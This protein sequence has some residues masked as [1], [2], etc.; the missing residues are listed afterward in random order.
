VAWYLRPSL[1][2]LDSLIAVVVSEFVAY[3]GAFV[4]GIPIYRFLYVRK[5]TAFWIAPTVGFL[6]GTIVMSVV[7][8]VATDLARSDLFRNAVQFGG[9]C[10]A[11]VGG[12]HWM[13][14][15]P[16]RQQR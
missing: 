6:V 12:I 4:I 15:R 7:F 13:I 16:D 3:I 14:A 2:D 10:G 5:L 1:V 11:L 9:V 8:S